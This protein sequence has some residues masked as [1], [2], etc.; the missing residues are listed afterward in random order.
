MRAA[1]HDRRLNATLPIGDD[2]QTGAGLRRVFTPHQHL[3][4]NL[5]RFDFHRRHDLCA[6]DI[7]VEPVFAGTKDLLDDSTLAGFLS[8]CEVDRSVSEILVFLPSARQTVP[9]QTSG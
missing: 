5:L 7:G 8:C 1:G 3:D 6:V 9:H 4:T 2:V